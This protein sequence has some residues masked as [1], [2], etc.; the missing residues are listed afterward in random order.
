MDNKLTKSVLLIITYAVLLVLALLKFDL[1]LGLIGSFLGALSPFFVGFAI[2]FVLNR[3]CDFFT[4]QY[5]RVL[6]GRGAKLAR[7]L[8]VVSSY[9]VLILGMAALFSFVLPKVAESIAL[10]VGSLSGYLDNLQGWLDQLV[11]TLDLEALESLKIDFASLN[12]YLNRLLTGLLQ[13]MSSAAGQVLAMTGSIFGAIVN[14][15]LA[16]VFSIYMLFGGHT[17]KRQCRKV[18]VAYAPPIWADRVQR[19]VDITAKT[20]SSFVTGQL[21]EACI[22]GGLCAVGML[23]IQADYAPLIGIIVGV[24]AL[25]PV[26]GA[27]LGAL[28]SA[29]L[30]VMVSP[31]KALIFLIFLVILQQVEGN[32]IY[33]RVVGTSIGLPGIWV[34]TAVTV[35]GGLF[36]LLGVLLSVPVASVLYTLL[37]QDVA[38]RLDRGDDTPLPPSG[39]DPQQH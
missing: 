19:V 6:K 34:L 9:L 2:A 3:P 25:I 18:L 11:R 10:F 36:G 33:P 20:F 4:R 15:V 13:T 31:L 28:L 24:S 26:A 14:L 7:P 8:A 16:T 38:R 32:V 39:G 37:R 1:L 12:T 29:F 5:G 17:L 27:Y 30:L 35:G 23:F 22:I 21:V